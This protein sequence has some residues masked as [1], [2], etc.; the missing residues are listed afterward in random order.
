VIKTTPKNQQN[1]IYFGHVGFLGDFSSM[2]NGTGFGQSITLIWTTPI[3]PPII[4]LIIQ[5]GLWFDP[6]VN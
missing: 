4:A 6:S 1:V 5:E 3:S 2:K